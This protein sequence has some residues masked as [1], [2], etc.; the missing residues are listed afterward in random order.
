M[1]LKTRVE[2]LERTDT[3][4][5]GPN[6]TEMMTAAV[7]LN[8]RLYRMDSQALLT[9]VKDKAESPSMRLQ[10]IRRLLTLD[11]EGAA[12][13]SLLKMEQAMTQADLKEAQDREVTAASRRGRL[14]QGR[15]KMASKRVAT[16]RLKEI[17][18][19]ITAIQV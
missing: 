2:R 8:E 11:I 3:S 17:D 1:A 9:L 13:L 12:R 16:Y 4:G 10:S 6:L 15:M 7:G 5:V 18:I 19:E 14:L